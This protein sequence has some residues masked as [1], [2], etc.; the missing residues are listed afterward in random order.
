MLLRASNQELCNVW[1]ACDFYD[2]TL[3][4]AKKKTFIL[5]HFGMNVAV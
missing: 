3:S 4:I 1:S 2:M 5:F